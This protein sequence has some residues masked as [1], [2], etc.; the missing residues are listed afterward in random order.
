MKAVV[1]RGVDQIAVDDVA[2]PK[3]EEP[4]DAIVRIPMSAI[5]GTD[6][7]LVRGT[8]HAENGARH[9][10]RSRGGRGRPRGR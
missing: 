10:A 6:L 9:G 5:C 2:D 8:M 4:T 1:W 3:I 7:H